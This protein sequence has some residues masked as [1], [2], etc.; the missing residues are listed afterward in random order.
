MNNIVSYRVRLA[1]N[2]H[3]HAFPGRVDALTRRELINGVAKTLS[4]FTFIPLEAND[5]NALALKERR[6]ISPEFAAEAAPHGVLLNGDNTVS[7]MLCEEDHLRIQVFGE[8]LQ[9]CLK[10]AQEAEDRIDGCHPL[11]FDETLG[12]LTACPTN[13]G[14]GFRASALMHLP[15][16]TETQSMRRLIQQAGASGLAV[17]GFYGEG[18]QAAWGYYQISNAVTLGLTEQE[19]ITALSEVTGQIAEFEHRAQNSLRKGDPVGL[20]D[21]VWRALGT[22]KNARRITTAEA[23]EC[24]A[25]VRLGASL[26]LLPG[27]TTKQ[28]DKLSQEVWPGLLTQAKGPFANQTERDEARATLLR[29]ALRE[30]QNEQQTHTESPCGDQD[31]A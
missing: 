21:R 14:T 31:G 30:V 24:L 11:A 26:A 1:R 4:D 29:D 15:A 17:R 12:F 18:T 2:I 6:L 16:L 10:T 5:T 20:E 3:G 25:A 19:I 28:I 8:D 23:M 22:A 13:L 7:V 27:I 9:Q